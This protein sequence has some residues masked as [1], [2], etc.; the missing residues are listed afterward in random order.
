MFD[1]SRDMLVR[2]AV[3]QR[4]LKLQRAY[5]NAIPWAEIERGVDIEGVNHPMSSKAEG[6]YK[7]AGHPAALSI[8]TTVPRPGRPEN[9]YRDELASDDGLMR[10]SFKD[11]GGPGNPWNESLRFAMRERLPLLYLWGVRPGVYAAILPVFVVSEDLAAG[12]F[13]VAPGDVLSTSE[14][15][16]NLD[17]VLRAG[18]ERAYVARLVRQRLHQRAF[19]ELVLD[20]YDHRC[21]MCSIKFDEFLEAA[22]IVPDRDERGRPEVPNGLALCSLHHEAYDRFLVD[23]DLDYRV[24]VSPELARRRDGPIFHAAFIER[25]GQ[26]I[27]LPKSPLQYPS[28]EYL[29]ERLRLAG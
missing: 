4:A 26:R 24:R 28:P 2:A 14:T 16:A 19:R 15:A 21:A 7:P 22:H 6:I 13:G 23:V 5:G 8:K 20:A 18:P 25:D 11:H 17:E 12:C 29:T 1:R 9:A 3:F 10:Y 27:H